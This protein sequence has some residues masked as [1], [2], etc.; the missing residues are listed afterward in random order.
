MST[1]EEMAQFVLLWDLVHGVVLNGEE[2]RIIWKFTA[3][4]LYTAKSA[5]EIQFRGSYC[6][7]KPGYLWS[8]YAEP[9][10][11]FFSWLLVQEKILTADKL[12]ARNWPC[13]PLCL[14]CKI[15]PE[16]AQHICLQCP[17]AQHV[18][19]LVQSWSHD[20]VRKPDANSTIEDWW[21]DS[22]QSMPKEQ[23]RTKAAILIYTVWN[24]WNERNRRTFQGKEAEPLMV[25]QLIKEEIGLRLRACGKPCVP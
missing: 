8:A 11:R 6:S 19:E 23:R 15:A 13:N 10:H 14:L 18:W 17:Y 3:D 5:Y 21:T 9:K 25:L 20:L 12:Q 4:G 1:V 7:F 16:S 24:L 22:L 2:D